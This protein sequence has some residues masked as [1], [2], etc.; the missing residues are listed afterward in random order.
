MEKVKEFSRLGIIS[1][2]FGERANFRQR[3][4]VTWQW[5][6][7]F[8][9]N[10]IDTRRSCTKKVD[11]CIVKIRRDFGD[12]VWVEGICE[13]GSWKTRLY[14]AG[15]AD[16]GREFQ[17]LEVIGINEL[18]NAFVRLVINLM[19]YGSWI[20]ENRVFRLS[21]WRDYRFYLARTMVIS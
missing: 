9:Y 2:N 21:F 20:L 11:T 3:T 18:A 8:F 16:R 6:A 19:V 13:C 12:W 14:V 17:S 4:T 5:G 1:V 7:A 15:K 10:D